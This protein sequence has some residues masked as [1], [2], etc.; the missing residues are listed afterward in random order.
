ML[1]YNLNKIKGE[2]NDA[3]VSNAV[4]V[5]A[6][7]ENL[8]EGTILEK[9]AHD[10]DAIMINLKP[11]EK[12]QRHKHI[13]SEEIV[14][15][16]NGVGFISEE[17]KNIPVETNDLIFLEKNKTHGFEAGIDGLK[18]IVFHGPPMHERV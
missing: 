14:L 11:T 6:D 9:C 12:I 13:T 3:Y 1:K 2:K 15:V 4:M 18:V 16:L 5:Y 8:F 7:K 17:E 10:I